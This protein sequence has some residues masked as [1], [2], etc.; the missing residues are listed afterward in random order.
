MYDD[1]DD[2]GLSRGDIEKLVDED[3]G[4][5]DE[6]FQTALQNGSLSKPERAIIKTYLAYK[7]SLM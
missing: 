3:I 1:G 7:L 6:F 2:G 5:F 4:K